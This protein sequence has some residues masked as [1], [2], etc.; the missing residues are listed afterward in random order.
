MRRSR[1]YTGEGW[2]LLARTGIHCVI[3][4]RRTKTACS[5]AATGRGV[6]RKRAAALND[7]DHD[8]AS[9]EP[10]GRSPT[11]REGPLDLSGEL[12]RG[13][14]QGIYGRYPFRVMM[15]HGFMLCGERVWGGFFF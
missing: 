11:T 14:R 7:R 9:D 8:D 3:A 1:G 10:S 13:V 5:E 2:R 4:L 15:D 6:R 12:E